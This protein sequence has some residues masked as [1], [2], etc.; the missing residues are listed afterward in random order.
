MQQMRLTQSLAGLLAFG[1]SLMPIAACADVAALLADLDGAQ[2]NRGLTEGS[3]K[4][5]VEVRTS[6]GITRTE[7]FSSRCKTMPSRLNNPS[8]P[9]TA[10]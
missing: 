1:L 10:R 7:R 2:P 6:T 9:R 4:A 8:V 3:T 5:I